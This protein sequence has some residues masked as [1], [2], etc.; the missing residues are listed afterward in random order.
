MGKRPDKLM[1][2]RWRVWFKDAIGERTL[3]FYD[4]VLY[5]TE[6]DAKGA[7]SASWRL[8]DRLIAVRE[9]PYKAEKGVSG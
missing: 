5:F 1:Q 7:I 4:G 6:E 8:K 3:P 9:V 2:E